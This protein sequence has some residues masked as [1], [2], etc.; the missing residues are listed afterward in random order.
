MDHHLKQRLVGAAVLIGIGV[1]FIPM[2]LDGPVQQDGAPR[3]T[4]IPLVVP[5][6]QDTPP[7]G[8]AERLPEPEPRPEEAE[9]EPAPRPSGDYAVQLGSFVSQD[10]AEALATRIQDMG[11]DSFVQ[12]TEAG[13][14]VMYRVRIG[15]VAL[16]EEAERLAIRL[17]EASGERAVVVT[18]P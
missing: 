7:R 8:Q 3:S 9:P 2:L 16:R 14:G 13:D 4:G 12:R 5:E 11:F 1:I 17:Q 10:N 15:P 6:P 18:H